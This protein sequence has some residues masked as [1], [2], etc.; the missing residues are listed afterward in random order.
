MRCGGPSV[1]SIGIKRDWSRSGGANVFPDRP[2]PE[3]SEID[4]CPRK[5]HAELHNGVSSTA[6]WAHHLRRPWVLSLTK[7]TC[8]HPIQQ[9]GR[10]WLIRSFCKVLN[11]YN[12]GNQWCF[13][14]A[15]LFLPL[16]AI[17]SC[18]QSL[19]SCRDQVILLRPSR[20]MQFSSEKGR[21]GWDQREGRC[22]GI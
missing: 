18:L 12:I 7:V 19:A 17:K 6:S 15:G 4:L 5:I 20:R 16:C 8:F 22:P 13:T 3:L 2:H 10:Y 21:D 14:G 11:A 1:S 9:A